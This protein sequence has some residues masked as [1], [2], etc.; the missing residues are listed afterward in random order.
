MGSV[1]AAEHLTLGTRVAVKLIDRRSPSANALR[2]FEQEARAAA[3]LR[4]PH[5]VQVLDYGVEDTT[6]YLV[7]E[8]LEGQSLKARLL[9]DG[10]LTLGDTWSVVSHVVQAISRAHEEGF[11]HRDLKPDNVF[12]IEGG[13]ELLV[14]VLD[15]GIAKALMG[16]NVGITNTGAVIGTPAYASPEQ[17]EGNTVDTRADLWSLGVMTFE[18]LTGL[19]PFSGPGMRALLSAICR[20]P[21]VVPSDVADVPEGFDEWFLQ[22][23]ERDPDRRFQSARELREALRPIIGPGAKR[24]W[25]GPL[26][27]DTRP[28][29][30]RPSTTLHVPTYPSPEPETRDDPRFPSAIPAGID[31]K[32]DL[33]HAAILCDTS[34]GGALLLT[35]HPFRVGQALVLSLHLDSPEHGEPVNA[36]VTGVE[37][38]AQ[39]VWKFRV[40]VRF[41][42]ALSDDL[43]ARLELKAR[44]RKAPADRER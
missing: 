43:R 7:M 16:P 4:S 19:Q 31:G 29:R 38:H 36:Q 20:D 37:P 1:W 44:E 28:Q 10:Q 3:M 12:L 15:F 8:L 40:G 2:R 11:V 22:A 39:A 25:V 34:Q 6:P 13:D 23:V 14:K 33:R 41:L 27:G 30:E 24:P 18:C 17:L 9:E 42:E 21:I 26:D 35:R 32:R 5:V